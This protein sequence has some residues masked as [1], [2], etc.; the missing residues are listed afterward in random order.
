MTFL[1]TSTRGTS[2]TT[3]IRRSI[4]LATAATLALGLL[5]PVMGP[6]ATASAADAYPSDGI[7]AV[8]QTPSDLP[9]YEPQIGVG[10]ALTAAAP[11]A[12]DLGAGADTAHSALVRLSIFDAP[13]NLVV[14]LAGAPALSVA[15]ARSA[16][17]TVLVPVALGAVTATTTADADAR[18][19]VLALFAGDPTTAGATVALPAVVTRADT[20]QGQ[21]SLGSGTAGLGAEPVTVGLTGLGGVP[22]TGVRAAHI[23]ASI[24]ATR[25]SV[26]T[27]DG[28]PIDVPTGTTTISTIVTPSASGDIEVSASETVQ[29]RLDVRGYVAEAAENELSLTGPGAYWPA[30]ASK[31]AVYALSDAAPLALPAPD[32]AG[33][34]YVLAMVNATAAGDL[35]MVEVGAAYLGRARGAVVDTEHGAQAQLALIPAADAAATLRRGS[36]TVSV[37]PLGS[38]LAIEVG[39]NTAAGALTI[40]SPV[41]TALDVSETL[42]FSFAGTAQTGGTAPLRIEVALDGKPYGSAAVRAEADTFA[43]DFTAAVPTSGDYDFEFTLVD[44]AGTRTTTSWNGS[45]TVPSTSDTVVAQ[46][47]VLFPSVGHDATIAAST[48]S[49]VTF[50]EDPYLSPGDI[51]VADTTPGAPEGL[52]RR[53]VAVDTVEGTWVVTTTQATLEDVFL[54]A[55]FTGEESLT[56][57]TEVASEPIDPADAEEV[58]ESTLIVNTGDEVGIAPLSGDV[59]TP[60]GDTEEVEVVPSASAPAPFTKFGAQAKSLAK[61]QAKSTAKSATTPFEI[62]ESLSVSAKFEVAEEGID[63]SKPKKRAAAVEG[64]AEFAL[65]LTVELKVSAHWTEGSLWPPKPPLPIPS[66]DVFSTILKSTAEASVTASLTNEKGLAKTWKGPAK[67]LNFAPTTIFV[68][69]IPLVLT[70]NLD[71]AM[72]AEIS[73]TGTATLASSASVKFE[74]SLGFT[75]KNGKMHKVDVGP[76]MQATPWSLDD[77]TGLT[78]VVKVA[79]GPELKYENKLYGA[80]GLALTFSVK[81]GAAVTLSI[82]VEKV[83]V[84]VELS[85]TMGVTLNFIVEVPLFGNAL[86]GGELLKVEKTYSLSKQLFDFATLFPSTEPPTDPAPDEDGEID[87]GQDELTDASEEVSA[88]DVAGATVLSSFFVEGPPHPSA[89]GVFTQPVGS[90]PTVGDDYMVMSTGSAGRLVD[91]TISGSSGQ[92]AVSSTRGNQIRDATTLRIDLVVPPEAN[93]LIGFDFRFYSDEYPNWVGSQFNDA[94]IVELDKSTWTVNEAEILAPRNFAFDELGNAITINSAGPW[95]INA[96]NAAG[97]AYGG[98]TSLLRATTPVTPGSHSLFLSIFDMG[99][100]AYD[101]AVLLDGIT[102]GAVEN[103]ATQCQSGVTAG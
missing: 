9:A 56:G 60:I 22:L 63:P 54:Q 3:S 12:I 16:S 66:I 30:E 5:L 35:T 34:A 79:L 69:P 44:R 67:G 17:T 10:D 24:D 42:A 73:L 26:I 15:S 68:G 27:I 13:S 91:S 71:V 86:F 62:K 49:S 2:R 19:E 43:W 89:V 78:G 75:Y 98:A 72:V 6:A 61:S 84:A 103:P 25:A 33:S 51:L 64:K 18:L 50:T 80:V 93:C 83:D 102:F 85:L 58:L 74:R 77:G 88:I 14:S 90:F 11:V 76:G 31:P 47:A 7:A 32:M 29:V 65:A 38:L 8:P 97:S 96:E 41:T 81:A 95:T 36:S 48:D 55:D 40:T 70:S 100:D 82:T 1:S 20:V 39:A 46:N 21:G 92:F 99:D 87:Y 28:Q 23:T 45:I 52:L 4:G 101:S 59:L 94:F 53:V 57:A 37:Q